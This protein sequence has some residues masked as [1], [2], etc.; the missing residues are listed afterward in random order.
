[1]SHSRRFE[2]SKTMSDVQV[3][4]RKVSSALCWILC[5]LSLA[6]TIAAQNVD[7]RDF[8]GTW[9]RV[10]ENGGDDFILGVDLPYKPATQD[11]AADHLQW[12]TEGRSKA[13]AHLTC[14]PTG[15]QG[16]TAP[17][18]AVLI[19][20][21]PQKMYFVSQEDREVRFIHLQRP[22][23]KKVEPSYSGDSIGRWEGNTFVVDTIGYNEKGQLDEMGNPQSDQLHVVERWTKSSDGNGLTVELTITDPVYY[24]KPFKKTRKFRRTPGA[25]VGDYDCAENPRSDD[26]DNLNFENDWFKPT[27]ARP[28]VNGVAGEKVICESVKQSSRKKP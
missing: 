25:R 19:M 7:P 28:V 10:A 26:Y 3:S 24:T 9:V 8:E 13:S 23:P 22:H 18:A 1:M 20:Q 11:L 14:R 6:T 2:E 4:C 12:F 15:V 17:K 5:G 16:V 21:T 27:C